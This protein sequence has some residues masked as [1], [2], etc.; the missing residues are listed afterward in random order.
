VLFNDRIQAGHALA[1]ALHKYHGRAPL[2]LAIPRGAVPMG[3][4]L[5]DDL[6]GELDVVMVR[7][8]GAPY[9]PEFA[10]GAVD[11]SGWIYRNP[12]AGDDP[13]VLRHIQAESQVQ[14]DVLRRRRAQHT[15]GRTPVD[16]A[17]RVVIV[18]DDG[19]ATGST[20]IAALHA[21]RSRK[22]ARLIC[23]VPVAPPDVLE[24]IGAYAD[25]VVCLHTPEDFQAV[26]QF[27]RHFDQVEDD[28]VIA[29]LQASQGVRPTSPRPATPPETPPAAAR[30]RKPV[31]PGARLMDGTVRMQLPD[32]ALDG[33]LHPGD[34]RRLVLFAHGS[35]SSRHS[36]RNRY[37]AQVL[38]AAG[39][40]TLLFDMLTLDEDQDVE[41]RFDIDLLTRRLLGVTDWLRAQA[42]ALS[43][44]YFGASTGAAAALRAAVALRPPVDAVVSR[45]GRP[46]L[47]GAQTLQRVRCPTL[48][49]VGS[50]DTEVL[51]L[52][53]QA[54][55]QIGPAGQL[56]E[57]AGATHL[58]EEAGT[59]E[60]AAQV[61]CDWFAQHLRADK[62]PAA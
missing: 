57:I 36:P 62:L 61:A 2:I 44:G 10:L 9:N 45:G 11:E 60:Q 40:G 46:D 55:A 26:G 31:S 52:N 48:L 8:I 33:E 4:A 38:H 23:A 7:K 1:R 6:Q 5:A 47:A 25:E 29:V 43:L 35:G 13:A 16:P 51:A 19:L 49:I 21:L 34:G 42:P 50:R 54:L 58:F 32:V 56:V 53:R 20:M 3:R 12:W 28:E 30:I 59:L 15:P 41:S 22:P 17:G 27:Y 14:L 24:K 37:V 18:V 39:I